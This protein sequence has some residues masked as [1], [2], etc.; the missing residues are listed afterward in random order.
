MNTPTFSNSLSPAA[1]DLLERSLKW[2]QP[3][4]RWYQG[5]GL[6]RKKDGD[7][8][9]I[10]NPEEFEVESWKDHEIY[11]RH[12]ALTGKKYA[13]PFEKYDLNK[14][15]SACALGALLVNNDGIRDSVYEEAARALADLV[16][17]TKL[18]E[19]PDFLRDYYGY[20]RPIDDEELKEC[21][22]E[23]GVEEIITSFNDAKDSDGTKMKNIFRRVLNRRTY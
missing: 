3:A 14:V 21:I 5:W 17:D 22:L 6:I 12:N 15:T 20:E 16:I 13:R 1:R 10:D 7:E 2:L 18:K 4:G 11:S 8:Y 9:V 19:D 23:D